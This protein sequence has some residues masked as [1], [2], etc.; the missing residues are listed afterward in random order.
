[1]LVWNIEE[2]SEILLVKCSRIVCR[3]NWRSRY[4]KKFQRYFIRNCCS[5]LLRIS[6]KFSHRF[7]GIISGA[8]FGAG[9]LGEIVDIWEKLWMGS[10]INLH[11]QC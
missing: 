9:C 4:L 7:P 2:S 6:G 5:N 10:Q 8:Y 1:M 3:K 11:K